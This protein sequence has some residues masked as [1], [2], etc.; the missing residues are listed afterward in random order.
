MTGHPP[1]DPELAAA[2]E[3]VRSE[4]PAGVTADMIPLLQQQSAA[5]P[6]AAADLEARFGTRL[7]SV[8]IDSGIEAVLACDEHVRGRRPAPVILF[9]HGGGM[10]M[11]NPLMG[12]ELVLPWA[13]RTGAVV[14]SPD[15]RL[16][17]QHPD[18][19]PFEDCW[20]TLE[21]VVASV[22]EFGGDPGRIIVTGHSA[23]AGLAA[24][25]ALRARDA[26][27]PALLGQLLMCPMLDDRQRT[28]SST[29]LLGEGVWDRVANHTGWTALLGD[30]VGSVD[31]G[32]H[33]APARADDLSGLAPAFLDV[34]SVDTFRDE[35][36][37]YA[38]RLWAAGGEA[39]LHVWPGA[40]HCFEIV[41]PSAGVSR[42]T[43]Q[44]RSDWIAR[45]L[46][47]LPHDTGSG[48]H[49][50]DRATPRDAASLLHLR[51]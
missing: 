33:A 20:R 13:A 19:A 7:R 12:L 30:R 24:A 16:A 2:L 49:D 37:D 39:E 51:Q 40:Y 32:T 36:V 3:A 5:T 35:V 46:G 44:A 14:V 15:Y 21:W 6:E 1:F 41:A 17:P 42:Q 8:R 38:T 45:K 10:I 23:G 9:I 28:P 31:V 26:G 18:P 4:M 48:V 50:I 22:A 11:G 25:L 47:E 29:E 27:G 34:G 43:L